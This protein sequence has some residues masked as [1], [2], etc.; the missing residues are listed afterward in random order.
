MSELFFADLIRET[1]TSTGTGPLSLDGASMGYRTFASVVPVGAE[2]HYSLVNPAVEG[3]WE[4]G[5]GT[6]GGDGRLN[7]SVLASSSQDALVALTAG[8]KIV[9]LTVASQWFAERNDKSDHGHTVEQIEGLA[10]ALDGKQDSGDYAASGHGHGIDD[11][12]GLQAALDGKQVAAD[13]A[14]SDHG[15]GITDIDG[16]QAAIDGKQPAGS[17]ADAAHGH[18]YLSDAPADGTQYARQ[19][20]VWAA[21]SESGGTTA[22]AD[23]NAA[24]PGWGFEN[25]GD[26]GFYR[27]ADNVLAIATA[28]VERVR[29][30][31][32]NVGIG[33]SSPSAR[34]TVNGSFAAAGG[35]FDANGFRLTGN[36]AD[37]SGSGQGV[38]IYQYFGG[39]EIRAYNRSTSA[40]IPMRVVGSTV[41]L[42]PN[43][44]AAVEV[45]SGAIVPSTDNTKTL[46]SGS[47]RWSVVYAGTGS[48]S[49]SDEREKSWRG[50]LND[51]EY[52]AG[53]AIL[54]ELGF[55][56]FDDAIVEKGEDAAR[57]H[58]GARAQ[59]VW[60]IMADHGLVDPIDANGRPGDTPYAFLCYDEWED[61]T[62]PVY[63]EIGV[64][65]VLDEDGNEIEA[66]RLEQ[67]ATGE[68][69]VTL[70][71]GNRYGLRYDELTLF[72]LACQQAAINRLNAAL[73]DCQP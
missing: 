47:F 27:P 14:A 3:D 37:F 8:A 19:D 11:V 45:S 29:F 36:G 53:C 9:T 49:T 73:A 61:R 58:F 72:L 66:A 62:E 34:L 48:I 23:G 6:L 28:G 21:I 54:G 41:V 57:F 60:A 46:G 44:T 13:Y 26:T 50:G 52:D 20:G 64:P 18:D 70:Q 31:G 5:V 59:R 4:V 69:R 68:M 1:T 56:Q 51:A 43:D 40:Y 16:L 10:S 63:E 2:F 38:E 65:A 15:H 24:E 35:S 71:A 30:A 42:A 17:Y 12:E 67:R 32:A 25:D 7:R 39:G 55:F 33:T 22:M